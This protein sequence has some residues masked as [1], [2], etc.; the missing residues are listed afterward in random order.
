MQWLCKIWRLNGFKGIHAW[1]CQLRR[2]R[3]VS[4]NSHVQKGIHNPFV[5]TNFW[6]L[7]QGCEELSWN[8]GRSTPRETNGI[9]ERVVR[10]VKEGTSSV[11]AQSG[12]QESWWAEA[13]ECHCFLR[14]VQ[15]LLA[16]GQTHYEHR[17]NLP[18]GPIIFWE[19]TKN[20]TLYLQKTK[21]GCLRSAQKSFLIH[22]WDTPWTR[23]G[24][25]LVI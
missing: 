2:R 13:T 17:C 3:E 12:L 4:E 15:D 25:G 1:P 19:P 18:C 6:N 24:V 20:P 10:R 9:A 5:R 11:L 22:S 8:H 23:D 14:N 21:V 16:D 7:W